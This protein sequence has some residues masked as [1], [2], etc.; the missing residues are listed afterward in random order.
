MRLFGS[1]GGAICLVVAPTAQA[2]GP[3]SAVEADSAQIAAFVRSRGK[4]V[5]SFT[6]YSGAGYEDPAAM[7]EQAGRVL[8]AHDA[9][10]TLVNIGATAAG[11]GAV[12]ELAKRRGF[13]TM[14]IVSVLARDQKL[15]LSPCVDFVFY[16]RDSEWGGRLSGSDK[17]SPTSAA[18]VEH[19]DELVGIGGGSI[20]ADEM[21]AARAAGKTVRFFPA[22][23]NHR[24]AID[25]AR[26]A[27][28]SEPTDFRG[29][30][31][32]ALAR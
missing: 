23:M 15:P 21:R 16:V 30:A 19:S 18:L 13:V 14:G 9:G 4:S 25:K 29:E 32:S 24:A 3:V 31:D 17:L 20:A 27:G 11:I 26:R 28:E 12:Y 22:D 6:G 7:L 2:C 5:L 8:A 1:L 10:K